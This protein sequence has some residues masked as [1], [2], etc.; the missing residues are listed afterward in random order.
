MRKMTLPALQIWPKFFGTA[1]YM[2]ALSFIEAAAESDRHLFAPAGKELEDGGTFESFSWDVGQGHHLQKL[3]AQEI[4]AKMRETPAL[5][6][7]LQTSNGFPVISRTFVWYADGSTPL[8]E[9][10]DSLKWHLDGGDPNLPTVAFVNTFIVRQAGTNGDV[11][12][13]ACEVR[14]GTRTDGRLPVEKKNQHGIWY[15]DHRQFNKLY[16]QDNLAY[17]L[18]GSAIPHCV[19]IPHMP[20]FRRYALVSFLRLRTSHTSIPAGVS[21]H[22]HG[23]E[24]WRCMNALEPR[25][26]PTF[27]CTEDECRTRCGNAR[28]LA[29]HVAEQH[30][31]QRPVKR[32]KKPPSERDQRALKRHRT[33]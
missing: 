20:G 12:P 29:R 33:K 28:S 7:W 11:D 19:R 32:Y 2:L 14:L 13:C 10:G 1:L 23:Q 22:E 17:W 4:A 6:E 31:G 9:E 30:H 3:V 16:P 24:V 15:T 27:M 25:P 8:S 21:M 5:G 26:V 18:F